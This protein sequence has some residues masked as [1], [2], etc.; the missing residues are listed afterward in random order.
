MGCGSR[1]GFPA[2]LRFLP[3]GP[4]YTVIHALLSRVSSRVTLNASTARLSCS[5]AC[6]VHNTHRRSI[7]ESVS[8]IL[9]PCTTIV[10]SGFSV[11]CKKVTLLL[12]AYPASSDSITPK[13]R[14][15]VQLMDCLII[16]NGA[17]Y[18]P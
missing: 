13:L 1:V 14:F 10:H 4:S 8:C 6:T 11:Y 3:Y 2:E 7:Q 12:G 16:V 5:T 18:H 17:H 15:S 9:D